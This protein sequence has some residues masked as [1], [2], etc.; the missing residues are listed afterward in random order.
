MVESGLHSGLG[1]LHVL[2]HSLPL[3]SGYSFRTVSILQEQ[4]RLGWRTLQ[5]TSPKHTMTAPLEE[6]VEGW[7]FLRTPM[8]SPALRGIP[9]LHEA[10]LIVATARRVDQVVRTERPDLIHAHSPV[11]NAL[12]ALYVGRRRGI[13]V[14]YEVRGLWED[15][16]VDHGTTTAD[17][18]RYRASREIETF[19]L[20]HCD[21]I[22]TICEGLRGELAGRGLPVEKI[23]LIP[24]AVDPA[25][26]TFGRRVDRDLQQRLDLEGRIVLGFIGSFYAYEGLDLLVRSLPMLL[27]AR[28][29]IALLLVGGGPAEA[30][31]KALAEELGVG[32]AIRFI[33]RVPH[34]EVAKYYDLVDVFVYPRHPMRLTDL[35]TPLKPLE[36]MAHGSIVLASDVGGHRE[37]VRDRVTGYLFQAGSAE[38]LAKTALDL[39][40]DSGDWPRMQ[41]NARHFV[42][43]E[44]TWQASVAGYRAAYGRALTAGRQGAAPVAAASTR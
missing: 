2:D 31:V 8:P 34:S 3:H 11:L 43:K 35:V 40:A 12:A 23:T 26:F 20:R 38:A 27:A 21:A 6:Q 13:P 1:I 39:L 36:A 22:T 19:A 17:S 5:L 42:E 14:V 29:D 24:N 16:A 41:Q 18:L 9:V 28:P 15:A 4:R 37:L 10:A 33:G 7:T 44:R 25:E 32:R 30:S